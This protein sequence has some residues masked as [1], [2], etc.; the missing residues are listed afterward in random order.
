MNSH[1]LSFSGVSRAML[2]PFDSL[3]SF[4]SATAAYLHKGNIA[5]SGGVTFGRLFSLWAAEAPDCSG[6]SFFPVDERIVPFDDLQSNW[7]AAYR[8]FLAPMNKAREKDHA[9]VTL[10][11]YDDILRHHFNTDTPVFDVIFLGV[12]DDGHT[13]S[14]F[15]GQPYLDDLS[16]IVL[17]TTSPKPPYQRIT[18]G[19][20]PLIAAKTV[21]VIIAGEGKKPI[22]KRLVEKDLD[23]PIAKVLSRRKN[24]QVWVERGLF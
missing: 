1:E 3:E 21:I 11:R 2:S 17:Q 9:A 20:A 24:S 12:G 13:A 6:A 15:P 14:L 22:F 18:L 7:G 10:S 19:M 4:A 23:L 8:N 5:L 16:S